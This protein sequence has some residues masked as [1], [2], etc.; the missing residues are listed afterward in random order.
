[1]LNKESTEPFQRSRSGKERLYEQ[2][3]DRQAVRDIP[4]YCP[5]FCGFGHCNMTGEQSDCIP[6][7]L[8]PSSTRPLRIPFSLM[9]GSMDVYAQAKVGELRQRELRVRWLLSDPE[10]SDMSVHSDNV[11]G[12]GG[13]RSCTIHELRRQMLRSVAHAS[14]NDNARVS[15]IRP[16]ISSGPRHCWK[17]A[18]IMHERAARSVHIGDARCGGRRQGS[19]G[20]ALWP[21]PLR[22]RLWWAERP[23]EAVGRD[24]ARYWRG[25]IFGSA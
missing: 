22:P 14:G 15:W 20:R 1:M 6:G 13:L 10:C 25:D 19:C 3:K 9:P 4:P 5:G 7:M 21:H 23:S 18:V 2:I 12:P 11:C 24:G 17:R 8:P 16:G